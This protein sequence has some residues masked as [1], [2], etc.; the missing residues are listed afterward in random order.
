MARVAHGVMCDIWICDTYGNVTNVVIC[1]TCGSDVFYKC[2]MLFSS[3]YQ[4][5]IH[6]NAF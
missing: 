6:F 2:I 4:A 1:D 5:D 3:S